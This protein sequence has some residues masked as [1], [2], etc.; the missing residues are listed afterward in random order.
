MPTA[1]SQTQ[2]RRFIS[3]LGPSERFGGSFAISNAQLGKTRNGDP[4]LKCLLSDKSGRLPARKWSMSEEMFRRLPTEGFVYVEGQTQP[5]QGELQLIVDTI[6]PMEP[7]SAELMDLLPSTTRDVAKMFAELSALM[8]TL[9]H[10]AMKALAKTY[11]DDEMLMEQFRLAPAAMMMHH[12]YL[13]GL[14]EHTLTLLQIADVLTPL[15]PKL[16]RDLVLMGLFLHDLGKTRELVYDKT[17]S[18]SDRGQLI[19]HLVEGA[20]MLHDKAAAV[21]RTEGTR[22]PPYAL[23]VLQHI[24]LSHHRLPE[25]GAAK[26][27]STP[28]AIFVAM[29][30]DLD[31]KTIIA[32]SAARPDIDRKFDLGG[33]F[34]ER[35]WALQNCKLFRPDPLA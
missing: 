34:T 26:P 6:E 9:E 16:N 33:N 21:M 8:D 23:T 3:D 15:Y 31:A 5:Y 10:P 7:S 28:E 14:L 20:I 30:D 27:P 19:G 18:Y 17:F 24:I 12:A 32:L 22:L 29:V 35:Q 1:A 11:L 25:Y 4:Y 13:G 2:S